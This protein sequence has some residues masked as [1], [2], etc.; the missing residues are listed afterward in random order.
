[1]P[2][3][4]GRKPLTVRGGRRWAIKKPVR[5]PYHKPRRFKS[6][7]HF[8]A[9]RVL[10]A[11]IGKSQIAGEVQAQPYK[12]LRIEKNVVTGVRVA[13]LRAYYEDRMIHLA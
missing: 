5:F 2:A 12:K 8:P 11:S 10:Q 6:G 9:W 4:H 1:M 3:S 7:L 13:T